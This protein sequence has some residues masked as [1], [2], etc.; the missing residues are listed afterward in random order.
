MLQLLAAHDC[1]VFDLDGTL[2]R[3]S[4]LIDGVVEALQLL[5]RLGK[6]VL[7]LTNN[8][9]HSRA[10]YAQ[11]CAALGLPAS[12]ASIYSSSYSAALYLDSI[13]FDRTKKVY[14][15]GER[16]IM[17]EL[18]AVGIDCFGGPDDNERRVSFA[19]EMAHDPQV[20][21]VVCGVDPGLNY[22]KVQYASLC[23]LNNPGCLFIATNSDARGHFTPRTEWAGAG[24]TVGAI[25]A[26]VEREPVLTGKPSTFTFDAIARTHGVAADRAI[27]V[28][29][30]LDTDIAWGHAAGLTTLLVLTGVTDAELLAAQHAG[31]DGSD[32]GGRRLCRPHHAL[33]SFGDLR[34]VA[35]EAERR[36]GAAQQLN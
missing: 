18:A 24:A 21:A 14:V 19:A 13:G 8:S 2:W 35:A 25:K 17:D 10:R 12:E 22:Y 11:K 7:Y 32:G 20:G 3:G 23:I 27:I 29:D 31:G 26:V 16:G 36:L 1:W 28:G 6:Q 9:M 15:V 5:L 30:R 4:E 34:L 33:A